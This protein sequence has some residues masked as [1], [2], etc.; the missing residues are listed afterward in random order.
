MYFAVVF[1]TFQLAIEP[2][3][4]KLMST[5]LPSK[6]LEINEVPPVMDDCAVIDPDGCDL[7]FVREE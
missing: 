3:P 4:E 6:S 5:A 2:E 1:G 7:F